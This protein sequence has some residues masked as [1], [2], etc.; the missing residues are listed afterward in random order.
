MQVLYQA[1]LHPDDHRNIK[2]CVVKNNTFYVFFIYDII[3][4]VSEKE[5]F[6]MV[7]SIIAKYGIK[8]AAKAGAKSGA[9]GAAKSAGKKIGKQAAKG[10]AASAT[11]GWFW[12]VLDY[13]DPFYWIGR[14]IKSIGGRSAARG[15]AAGAAKQAAK[16]VAK[17]ATKRGIF[18]RGIAKLGV[19][20]VMGSSLSY[21]ATTI[22]PDMIVPALG[23]AIGTAGALYGAKKVKQISE[24][25]EKEKEAEAQRAAQEAAALDEQT[26]RMILMRRG[27]MARA[28]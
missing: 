8:A 9:K 5:S 27:Q 26:R 11:D 25:K 6:Q 24:R 23:A 12:K 28:A 13:T 17:R 10:A 4:S 7:W 22:L 3:H 20:G 18:K 21:A 1:E 14:G 2:H 15:V 19:L 16:G